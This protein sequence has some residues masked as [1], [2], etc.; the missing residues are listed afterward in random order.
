[1]IHFGLETL[2]TSFVFQFYSLHIFISE[3]RG[4][5]VFDLQ[6]LSCLVF[7]V[8]F[9]L[10]YLW[11]LSI[12][13]LGSLIGG[14]KRKLYS[15]VLFECPWTILQLIWNYQSLLALKIHAFAAWFSLLLDKQFDLYALSLIC[16]SLAFAEKILNQNTIMPPFYFKAIRVDNLW[17]INLLFFILVLF[18]T[19]LKV[20]K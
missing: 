15:S 8:T 17:S 3:I 14:W 2:F 4:K 13:V 11:L 16:P 1:M 12:L 6:T 5:L 19:A 7:G 9:A 10:L 20:N 18:K